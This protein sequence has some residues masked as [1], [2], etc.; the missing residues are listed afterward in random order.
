MAWVRTSAPAATH[1]LRILDIGGRDINGH[2][3]GLFHPQSEWEVV[4]LVGGPRVTWIGDILDYGDIEPFDVA[5]CLEVAEH[6]PE[7][8]DII[9]HAANL[10]TSDDGLFIFTAAGPG[11][12]PHSAVDGGELRPGEWYQNID[13]ADL[14]RVLEGSFARVTVNQLGDDVRAVAVR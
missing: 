4:D 13:P 1:P 9:W 10:L 12:A 6:T 8:A 3:G 2:P 14:R 11:R 7:W 5:L